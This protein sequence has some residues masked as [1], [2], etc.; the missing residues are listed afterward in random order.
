MTVLPFPRVAAAL[1]VLWAAV[2]VRADSITLFPAADCSIIEVVPTNSIGAYPWLT[3]GTTQNYTSN[4]AL[5]RFDVAASIPAG[6]TIVDAG[7]YVWVTRRPADDVADSLFSL[8]RVLV[9]WA[10][11]NNDVPEGA[12]YAIIQ[13]PLS[14]SGD[15]NWRHRHWPTQTWAAPGGLE[16]T[17]YSASFSSSTYIAG[18]SS[19]PYF[20]EGGGLAVDAQF[21]LDQPGQN[22][23]WM[24]KSEEEDNDFTARRFGSRELQDETASPQLV[25]SYLPPMIITEAQITS[26]RLGMTFHAE[27]GFS[28]RMESRPALGGTNTWTTLTNF[29]LVLSSGPRV[30]TDSLSQTQRFYRLRRN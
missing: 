20:F 9:S 28:Y 23:G 1:A 2:A 16:G 21:W 4:R 27:A 12:S 22:H 14:G 15:A 29:G 25:I 10:E 6:S 18:V 8:R 17:D 11:G 19:T 3:A 30:V 7:L 24:L 26:N 13:A 5:L